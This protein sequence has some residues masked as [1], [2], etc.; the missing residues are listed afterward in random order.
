ME[1]TCG[2][3]ASAALAVT[4]GWLRAASFAGAALRISELGRGESLVC[5]HVQSV[6]PYESHERW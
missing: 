6:G 2:S 5:V 3:A 4:R 1:P